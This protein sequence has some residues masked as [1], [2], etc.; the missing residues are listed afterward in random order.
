MKPWPLSPTLSIPGHLFFSDI[1]FL[2]VGS[3]RINTLCTLHIMLL[4]TLCGFK[5]Y[6]VHTK[7]CGSF[8]LI[9]Y[10]P[11]KQFNYFTVTW[12]FHVN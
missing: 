3:Y 2:H 7:P 1:L 8:S 6:S 9:M 10:I 5:A 4:C 12:V 11:L